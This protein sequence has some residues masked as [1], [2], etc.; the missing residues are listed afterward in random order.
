MSG[1]GA[2]RAV[3][4]RGGRI[5]PKTPLNTAQQLRVRFHVEGVPGLHY[6]QGD[7]YR[8]T[9]SHY[10]KHTDEALRA[11]AYAWL[12]T[13]RTDQG[14]VVAPNRRMVTDVLDALRGDAYAAVEAEPAWL[15]PDGGPDPSQL[16][17]C[18]NALVLLPARTVRPPNP[19]LF[20]TA[21]LPLDFAPCAP[22][23][24][25]WLAFL[26]AM[27]PGDAES[28]ALLQEFMALAALTDDTRHQ[29][30]LLVVGPRRSG[31]GT[32]LR[33]L[34]AL[35]G[36]ANVCSPT[37]ASLGTPFGLQGL[38]GKRVAMVSDARLSGRTDI[39]LVAENILRITGE[40]AIS[41]PRKHRE[42]WV[43]KLP[44]RFV[45][46]TNELPSMADAS[47]ALSSR[48]LILRLTR[49]FYGA[50]DHGLTERLMRELPGILLWALD[51]LDRL[52]AR[53]RLVQ[54]ASGQELV[55]ELE[56]LASP[57]TMFV[58]DCCA[59]DPVA[60]TSIQSLHE[61]WAEWCREQGRD[62]SGTA[63]DM[64]KKLRAAIP[65][66]SATQPRRDGRRVRCYR[67]IRFRSVMDPDPGTSGTGWNGCQSIA[68]PASSNASNECSG[69]ERVPPRANRVEPDEEVIF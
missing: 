17:V 1:R 48:F 34:R 53:G 22:P 57:V 51:G 52:R 9:G 59:L 38:I 25:H 49:S 62:H 11:D 31:K 27:F 28:V 19:R 21:S 30:A 58:R 12:A 16:L 35:A 3:D 36:D 56:A 40:D 23:P 33:V 47:A 65:S 18:R 37:F 63:A 10:G 13:C 68:P 46:A 8:W 55:D 42:D 14:T 7:F 69:V 24:T 2:L 45:I 15:E 6:W 26:D 43:G 32:I 64:G 67:G 60:E 4:G 29:K 54:P 66:L 50:E 61:R 44:T 20:A 41:V 5:D 39:A